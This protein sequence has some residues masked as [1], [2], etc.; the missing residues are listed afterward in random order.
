MNKPVVISI[1]LVLILGIGTILWLSGPDAPSTKRAAE[2]VVASEKVLP[3]D[4]YETAFTRNE[5]PRY[6]YQVAL[7]E[8]VAQ[9][10]ELWD[11]YQ[12]EG[13]RP[14]IDFQEKDTLFLGVQESGTC[15]V[16]VTSLKM[17][18]DES[19][20]IRLQDR[21]QDAC[22]DDATPRTFVLK[23]EKGPVKTAIV[24]QGVTETA[25]PLEDPGI[26][27]YVTEIDEL[28]ER[29]LVVASEAKDYS[30]TGGDP[31]FYDAIWF[32]GAPGG[33]EVGSQ[34]KVWFDEVMTSYPGQ[35]TAKELQ[36]VRPLHPSGASR[37][38][39]EVIREALETKDFSGVSIVL[40][41]VFDGDAGVWRVDLKDGITGEEV[42]VK[43]ED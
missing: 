38:Q 41:V 8:D 14:E 43:V 39:Q 19:V 18:G 4:F 11:Y 16:E 35:S 22:T 29:I 40:N 26:V 42:Q 12:F 31:E 37:P 27:G 24:T 32:S 25:V 17:E 7:A 36:V 9:F 6:Q 1:L 20:K 13:E 21:T 28:G 2:Q 15:P 23:L 34:A 10:E 30:A 33:V 5:P 3:D